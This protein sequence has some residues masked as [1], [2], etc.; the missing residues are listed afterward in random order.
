[1][2]PSTL[3]RAVA[4]NKVVNISDP[5][6]GV[7]ATADMKARVAH[8]RASG[9]DIFEALWNRHHRAVKLGEGYRYEFAETDQIRPAGHIGQ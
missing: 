7:E 1:M 2:P 9:A 8:L 4:V 5:G 6:R 3:S